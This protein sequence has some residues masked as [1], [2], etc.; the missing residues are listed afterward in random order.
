VRNFAIGIAVVAV[1][2]AGFFVA[3]VATTVV[4]QVARK[5]LRGT[6]ETQQKTP[7]PDDS[8]DE[9]DEQDEPVS[10]HNHQPFEVLDG[11]IQA[12]D[13]IDATIGTDNDTDS[14]EIIEIQDMSIFSE[15]LSALLEGNIVHD[16]YM[17]FIEK[18][19]NNYVTACEMPED[20]YPKDLTDVSDGVTCPNCKEI[21]QR[22]E[23]PEAVQM[24]DEEPETVQK[25]IE[26]PA[27]P[28]SA[29]DKALKEAREDAP[30][31]TDEILAAAVTPEV[32]K[33]EVT[34][35]A[36]AR[37]TALTPEQVVAP[38]NFEEFGPPPQITQEVQ[39]PRGRLHNKRLGTIIDN[40]G[41]IC[42]PTFFN[43]TLWLVE[44]KDRQREILFMLSDEAL[45]KFCQERTGETP[46]GSRKGIIEVVLDQEEQKLG[47]ECP[48]A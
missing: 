13:V 9:Q 27:V 21:L 7:E 15:P 47:R 40:E 14:I 22:R 41:K 2:A 18:V 37:K 4:L 8:E 6:R 35:P 32:V 44:D 19:G 30:Q 28:S 34:E 48:R 36:P 29:L 20:K 38:T 16:E 39:D 10:E 42:K 45:T 24:V 25:P 17:H 12:K 46:E 1:T 31:E 23:E 43:S 3:G 33:V 5:A 26:E 11:G